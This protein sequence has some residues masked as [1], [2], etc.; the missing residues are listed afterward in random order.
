MFKNECRSLPP[1]STPASAAGVQLSMPARLLRA[2]SVQAL[3]VEFGCWPLLES[4]G[5]GNDASRPLGRPLVLA[6]RPARHRQQRPLGSRSGRVRCGAVR[7]E[8]NRTV[9]SGAKRF[10]FVTGAPVKV[11]ARHEAPGSGLKRPFHDAK[12]V[13]A[14]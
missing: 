11:V 1:S 7:V 9:P 13:A 8:Q 10:V 3:P 6:P 14:T 2:P 5:A 4:T 12:R